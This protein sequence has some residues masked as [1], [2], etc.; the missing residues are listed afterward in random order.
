MLVNLN[1]KEAMSEVVDKIFAKKNAFKNFFKNSKTMNAVIGFEGKFL[2]VN[3]AWEK[4]LGFSAQELC[5]VTFENFVHP[6][7]LKK[8]LDIYDK[9][10]KGDGEAGLVTNR[11][12][13]KDGG[14]KKIA[15]I[16][17]IEGKNKDY[18]LTT[19]IPLEKTSND[20]RRK[21]KANKSR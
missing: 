10:K 19:A 16:S 17:S 4:E 2:Y 3:K 7:D 20:V 8:T 21:R 11:Y 5:A 6:D 9:A 18:W 15:W 1:N 12:L 13:T 14:Y